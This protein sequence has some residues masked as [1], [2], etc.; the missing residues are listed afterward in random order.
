MWLQMRVAVAGRY[1]QKQRSASWQLAVAAVAPG[2]PQHAGQCHQHRPLDRTML[3]VLRAVRGLQSYETISLPRV[4]ILGMAF[5]WTTAQTDKVLST[6]L[7]LA[8]LALVPSSV[9]NSLSG[10]T[11][12]KTAKPWNVDS[13]EN[14]SG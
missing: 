2:A 9:R 14:A 12:G 4:A 6:V 11:N 10:K 7:D 8:K 5:D 3:P 1:V 13:Q